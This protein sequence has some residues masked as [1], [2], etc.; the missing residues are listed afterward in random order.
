M[1]TTETINASNRGEPCLEIGCGKLKSQGAI[2]LDIK[3]T[4]D[5]DLLSDLERP[6]PFK[7]ESFETII[8]NQ[9]VEHIE[10][11]TQLMA[12]LH[13][14]LKKN[15]KLVIHVPYFR[16]SW[17]HIDPT[18]VRSFT[19]LT[20]DYWLKDSFLN[21]HYS[22]DECTFTRIDK[23]LDADYRMHPIRWMLTKIAIRFPYVYENSLFS[24]VFPFQ[25]LSIVCT[26]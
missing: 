3:M 26:K 9:V 20:F 23:Y 18:H 22:F 1:R 10:N 14:I 8:A 15:G 6:L 21:E 16:S 24:F 13:R 17:S 12:E 2:G 7:D 5:V 19:L 4:R 11:F 25:Q